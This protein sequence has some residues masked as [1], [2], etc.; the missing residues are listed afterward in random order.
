MTTHAS[1]RWVGF[2]SGLLASLLSVGNLAL[3]TSGDGHTSAQ[4]QIAGQAFTTAVLA[5]R[6][7]RRGLQ[8]SARDDIRPQPCDWNEDGDEDSDGSERL[9]ATLS[10]RIDSLACAASLWAVHVG[11]LL[12]GAIA[13]LA[14][15]RLQV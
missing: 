14:P 6:A 7:E 3:A 9:A 11:G 13:P 5:Q 1:Y 15:V 4:Q 12:H 2:V 8:I 10:T